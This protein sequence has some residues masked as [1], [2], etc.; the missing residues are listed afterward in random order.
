MFLFFFRQNLLQNM[1]PLIRFFLFLHTNASC[2]AWLKILLLLLPSLKIVRKRNFWLN[3]LWKLQIQI[4]KTLNIERN[5][6]DT[7]SLIVGFSSIKIL[8][9]YLSFYNINIWSFIFF[10]TCMNETCAKISTLVHD[11]ILCVAKRT[12]LSLFTFHAI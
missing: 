8:I 9:L 10:K 4:L 5:E 2:C 1:R 3:L 7:S 11:S 6:Y 12:F